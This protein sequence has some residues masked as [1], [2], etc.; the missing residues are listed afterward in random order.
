VSYIIHNIFRYDDQGRL[1]EEWVQ[2]D[3]LEF[4]KQLGVELK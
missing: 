2:L 4:L 1:A 3:N